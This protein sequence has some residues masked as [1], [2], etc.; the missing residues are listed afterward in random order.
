MLQRIVQVEQMKK[1]FLLNYY[2]LARLSNDAKF[3]PGK[4]ERSKKKYF[5]AVERSDV[6]DRPRNHTTSP[7]V[8]IT[9][10][11]ILLPETR[12]QLVSF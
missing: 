5:Q 8:W 9:G 2:F 11:I 4:D 1:Q 3:S 12:G 10:S 6:G 7:L